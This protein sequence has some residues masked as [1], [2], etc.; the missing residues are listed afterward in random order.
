MNKVSREYIARTA[1]E[2]WVRHTR[3]VGL[4][5]FTLAFNKPVKTKAGK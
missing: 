4:S 2:G 5:P 3:I 1:G